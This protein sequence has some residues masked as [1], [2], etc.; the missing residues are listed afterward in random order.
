[1]FGPACQELTIVGIS[2]LLVFRAMR[3]DD[4]DSYDELHAK[5]LIHP[6]PQSR[7][8]YSR[9]FIRVAA[10]PFSSPPPFYSGF[11]ADCQYF[12]S[13]RG[14]LTCKLAPYSSLSVKWSMTSVGAQRSNHLSQIF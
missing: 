2:T 12:P 7:H 13:E 5:I 9:F 11:I 8:Q 1:M 10:M 4:H 6:V 14:L 3:T